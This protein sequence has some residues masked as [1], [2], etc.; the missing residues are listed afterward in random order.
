MREL[1]ICGAMTVQTIVDARDGMPKLLEINP[2][3]GHNL[4]YRTE[5]GINEPLIYLRLAQGQDPGE[6]P[7]VPEGVLLLDP[8]R[9]IL[10]VLGQCLDQGKTWLHARFGGKE[11][12]TKPYTEDSIPQLLRAFRSEYFGQ[13]RRIT[14]P[15]NRGWFSDPLPTLVRI[16]NV[17]LESLRRR[18]A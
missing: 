10:H 1:G 8:L 14:S 9:D 2:R 5:L 17:L 18:V 6:V 11:V 7:A 3:F 16:S 15:L 12:V 13:T 4:W